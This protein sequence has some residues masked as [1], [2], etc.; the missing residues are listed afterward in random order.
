MTTAQTTK[1]KTSPVERKRFIAFARVSSRAQENEGTSLEVQEAALRG[2]AEQQGGEVVRLWRIAE[3]ASKA[4][5]RASFKELLAYARANA[6]KIDG[7]LAYK[8]DRAARNMADYGRLL[9]L[10]V[11]HGVP[12][13]AISQPTQDTPAGRMA[14]NMMAAM[15]TFFAEQLSVD[16]KE[17]LA[18]RVRDGWFPTVAPYGY[19]SERIDGR[20]VVKVEPQEAENV[21]YVFDLYAYHHC[22]IDMVVQRLADDGRTYIA[23]QPTWAR[24]KIHRV[25]RDR[26]YIGDLKWHGHWQP[27]RHMPIVDRD[28][29]TRVQSLLG[30]KVYK[31]NELLYGGELMTCG[32][33]GRPVTGEVVTKKKSGKRYVY[34]RCAGYTAKD[35]P[36]DRLREEEVDAEVCAL[37]E[38][39]QQPAPVRAWFREALIASTAHQHEQLRTRCSELQRQL[40]DVRRQQERLLNLHLSGSIDE[41]AFAAKN[42]ELRDLVATLTEQLQVNDRRKDEKADLALRVFELSQS[43]PQKWVSADYSEKRRIMKMVCLNLVLKGASLCIATRKPFNALVEGLVV[44]DSGEGEIRTPATLAGR[45][46]FETGAFS[47]SATSPERRRTVADGVADVKTAGLPPAPALSLD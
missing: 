34:Y 37:F 35:R 14:R 2:Y 5:R 10:E 13:I 16:V 26:S 23:K 47:R 9:E 6:Q 41:A 42:I 25:L 4:E 24:S 12:L 44:S 17:G 27:G 39:L 28:T 46:V 8:V 19:V 32:H 18:Q 33:C 38:K 3:T 40:D 45:P 21:R 11:R 7:L 22:T 20:S 15:G 31:R 36:R 30:E 29:F 43:I 1:R